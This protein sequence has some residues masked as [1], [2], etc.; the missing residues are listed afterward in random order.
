MKIRRWKAFLIKNLTNENWKMKSILN[1]KI[2]VFKQ[3]KMNF[4][5]IDKGD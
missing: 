2:C 1:K 5:V 3:F 4:F